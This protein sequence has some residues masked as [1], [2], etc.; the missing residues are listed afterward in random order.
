MILRLLLP[1]LVGA[2]VLSSQPGRAQDGAKVTLQFLSFPKSLDPEPVELLVGDGK[3]IKVEIPSSELSRS[4][5]VNAQKVWAI[6]ESTTDEDG[7]PTFKVWGKAPA[8]KARKQLI[9]LVRKGESYGDG[10]EVIPV[11]GLANRF[12]GG[13]FLFLNAARVDVAG[14]VG[15]QKF[16][17]R[18]GKHTIIKPAP[19]PGRNN[20]THAT[21]YY[22]KG[23]KPRPFFSSRWPLNDKARALIFL[24]HDPH[25][26]RIRLHSIRDFL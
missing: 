8:L 14:E 9:I 2:L 1:A 10:F 22:R 7:K 17:L 16:A 3:T 25:T 24:Y 15:G 19:L 6:G 23:D 26:E 4:Y 20:L 13:K 12:G 5:K 11:D 18:P 21:L